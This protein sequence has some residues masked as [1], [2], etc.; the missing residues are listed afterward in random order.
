[1][2]GIS[3]FK[4]KDVIFLLNKWD[5]ISHMDD[6]EQKQFLKETREHLRKLLKDVDEP[7]IFKTSATK[8]SD[9]HTI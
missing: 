5:T 7:C 4:L 8:V 3:T 6:T 2:D 9:F 1:M